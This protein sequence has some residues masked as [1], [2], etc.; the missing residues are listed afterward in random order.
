[1][2]GV[3][4]KTSIQE[5]WLFFPDN[6]SKRQ[7]GGLV[8]NDWTLTAERPRNWTIKEEEA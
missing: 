3:V 2:A 6:S 7:Y 4:K 5:G 1:M 8:A